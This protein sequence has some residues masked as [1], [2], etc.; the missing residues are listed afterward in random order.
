MS[1]MDRRLRDLVEEEIRMT[2]QRL[3]EPAPGRSHPHIRDPEPEVHPA[4]GLGAD[5]VRGAVAEQLALERVQE[6]SAALRPGAGGR[7]P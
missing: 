5:A 3:G 1:R 6:P 4:A 7:R 2:L